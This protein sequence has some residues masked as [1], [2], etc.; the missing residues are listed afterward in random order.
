MRIDAGIGGRGDLDRVTF[1]TP[2]V[3]SVERVRARRQVIT[4]GE[5]HAVIDGAYE[6][7][8]MHAVI[9]DLLVTARAK[10]VV[11]T[12]AVNPLPFRALK[13]QDFG[14]LVER[15]VLTRRPL[16]PLVH[17]VEDGL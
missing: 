17:G 12:T 11:Y 14:Q 2:S 1:A 16:V 9:G 13:A 15:D 6:V 5:D 4:V 8:I 10:L 7:D 3:I